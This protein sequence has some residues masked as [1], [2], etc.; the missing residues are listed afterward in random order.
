MTEENAILM[1]ECAMA[2]LSALDSVDTDE[3]GP[4]PH[5]EMLDEMP[6]SIPDTATEFLANVNESALER[7]HRERSQTPEAAG[8]PPEIDDSVRPGAWPLWVHWGRACTS[9]GSAERSTLQCCCK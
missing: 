4:T 9:C 2:S 5:P 3:G 1:R 6:T 8:S 7:Y